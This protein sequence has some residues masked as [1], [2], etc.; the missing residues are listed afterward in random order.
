MKKR[1]RAPRDAGG[2]DTGFLPTSQKCPHSNHLNPIPR[3]R[4]LDWACK[5][6][7]EVGVQLQ[8]CLRDL[9]TGPR[10]IFY[11]LYVGVRFVFESYIRV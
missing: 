1:R 7:D 11:R 3:L 5:L 9:S 6:T 2:G 8:R 10:R 4:Q